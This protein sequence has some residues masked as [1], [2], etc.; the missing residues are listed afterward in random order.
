MSS[1]FRPASANAAC[2]ASTAATSTLTPLLVRP[3]PRMESWEAPS[4][5]A[6]TALVKPAPQSM[7]A[8]RRM[9]RPPGGKF[10]TLVHFFK[11]KHRRP[12]GAHELLIRAYLQFCPQDFLQRMYHAA[13][14]GDASRQGDVRF[15]GDA[16]R[17]RQGPLGNRQV[18]PAKNVFRL[19]ALRQVG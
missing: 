7:P 18:H 1:R 19:L 10:E 14:K 17:Q 2:S 11:C 16:A 6:T 5:A 12:D 13:V 4:C 9:F 3:L 15:D 8:T